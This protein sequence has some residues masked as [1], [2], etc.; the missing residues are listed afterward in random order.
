VSAPG[1]PLAAKLGA[2]DGNGLVD[3]H[4]CAIDATWSALKLVRGLAD[5]PEP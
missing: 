2:R 1:R 3:V 5:R 4:V